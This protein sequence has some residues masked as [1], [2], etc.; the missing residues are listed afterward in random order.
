MDSDIRPLPL[1][2]PGPAR[3]G[4]QPVFER[5]G[6]IGLGLIGASLAMAARRAW[7]S[8]LVIGVDGKAVLEQAIAAH[9]VDVAASDLTILGE[10]DVVVL[11]A[12]VLENL[13]LIPQLGEYIAKPAVVTDVGST[14]RTIA[15]AARTLP[16]HLT[17]VGGHPLAGAATGGIGAARPDLFSGRPWFLVPAD[18]RP[19]TAD[20][21][22]HDGDTSRDPLERLVR[23]TR[24]LGAVPRA[25]E[26]AAHDHL[27]A[28]LSHLPQLAATSLMRAVGGEVGEDG[29]ALAGRGFRDTTRL[30]ASPAT[31][32]TDICRDNA[33]EIGA[34]LDRLIAELT[35][36]RDRLEDPVAVEARFDEAN[37][38]RAAL[39]GSA[40]SRRP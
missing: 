17:F 3:S 27:V 8:A 21:N 14:K 31:I 24:G 9:A 37:R 13:A 26:A 6:I 2:H 25:I 7:P 5:I 19:P 39:A 29:L 36:L 16:P 30:A 20:S 11:A 4:E 34:A 32:W 18:N 15:V 10:A 1:M 40:D 22:G 28:F 23:F 33:D 35:S 12:P 38:W